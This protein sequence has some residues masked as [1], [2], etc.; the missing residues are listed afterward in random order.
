MVKL[1]IKKSLSTI[2][3]RVK[4]II[5]EYKIS[6]VKFKFLILKNFKLNVL[7]KKIKVATNTYGEANNPLICTI[8]VKRIP[9][10][11]F[12]IRV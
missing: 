1:L 10:T 12:L 11:M 8:K 3:S 7:N 9:L 2:I 5:N 4:Q 6:T